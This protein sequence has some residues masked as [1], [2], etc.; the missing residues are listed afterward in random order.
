MILV[1]RI[2]TFEPGLFARSPLLI[3]HLSELLPGT[4]VYGGGNK[5]R[6][7]NVSYPRSG[8]S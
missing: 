7:V 5:S 3:E 4:F 2:S 8:W 6:P 1:G